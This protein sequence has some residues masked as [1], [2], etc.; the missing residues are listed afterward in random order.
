MQYNHLIV[1]HS[2]NFAHTEHKTCHP[3][4]A[5]SMCSQANVKNERALFDYH[6]QTLVSVLPLVSPWLCAR[7]FFYVDIG[8]DETGVLAY[9][10]EH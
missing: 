10:R 3:Q 4:S 6:H 2:L 7:D 9:L 1:N 5:E 8:K